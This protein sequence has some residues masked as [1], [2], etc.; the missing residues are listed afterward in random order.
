[1]KDLR[2]IAPCNVSYKIVAKVFTNQLKNML[3]TMISEN[4]STLVKGRLIMNNVLFASEILQSMKRNVGK[5]NGEVALK[6]DI[7]K[8]YD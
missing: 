1:M 3:S 8:A 7:S 5:K 6:I 2:P 4:Q